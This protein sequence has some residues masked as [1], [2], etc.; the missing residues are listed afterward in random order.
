[1]NLPAG[2]GTYRVRM[3]PY[4]DA[5]FSHPFAGSVNAELS[6]RIFVEVS[7]DGVDS[8][9]FASVI[10]TCWATPVNDPHHPLRWDLIVDRQVHVF[11]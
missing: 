7:V 4:Q 2:Q 9:Q 1:M 6:K 8:H 11:D 10:D 3:I 5:E